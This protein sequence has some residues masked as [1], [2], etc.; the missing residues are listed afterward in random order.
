MLRFFIFMLSGVFLLLCWVLFLYHAEWGVFIV[1]LSEVFLLLCWVLF[2]SCWVRG[3]YCY[4]ECFYFFIFMQSA[5]FCYAEWRVFI[6][7]LSVM[8]LLLCR[9]R[10][11]FVMLSV[12]FYYHAR[13]CIFVAMLS[14]VFLLSCWVQCFYCY[15]DCN[16]TKNRYSEYIILCCFHNCH[17]AYCYPGCCVLLFWMSVCKMSLCW[18]LCSYCSECR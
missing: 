11:F 15:A 12:V 18:M 6:V 10:C 14:D 1:I 16:F 8:F 7:V 9:V 17:T 2:I 5:V 4:A 3:F 13:C